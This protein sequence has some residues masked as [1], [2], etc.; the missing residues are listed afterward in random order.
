MKNEII[1]KELEIQDVDKFYQ[2]I[3]KN[4]VKKINFSKMKKVFNWQYRNKKKYNFC[5]AMSKKKIIGVQ[6]FVPMNHYD[7]QLPKQNLFQ[8]F[9][10]VIEG[11]YIGTSIKLHK[12]IEK[13]S[14]A[15]FIGV[16]GIDKVTHKFHQWLGFTINKMDHHVVFSEKKKIFKIAIVRKKI[17]QKDINNLNSCDFIE[18]NK[19]NINKLIKKNFFKPYIP[20]KSSRFLINRYLNNPF[21][22]YLVFSIVQKS[23]PRCIIVIR[24][25]FIKNSIVL[26]FVDYIGSS[27]Y[28][29]LTFEI[30]K[31]LIKKYNAEYL[32]IYSYGISKKILKKAGYINRYNVKNLIVPNYFEPF[33]R[34]NV[35]IFCAF[36]TSLNKK[37]IKLFK[38]DGDGDRPSIIN[39]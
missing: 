30:S 34:E 32:D 13:I 5:I 4:W 26:R 19:K 24:P 14:N 15:N 21:Y 31:K 25:I 11:K 33:V 2:I 28:F 16:I 20:R 8:A 1:L 39:F 36:K 7:K 12:F 37:K 27:S 6:G 35:D 10:R 22:K 18:L 23:K 38:G 29:P 9:L 17:Y 3:K